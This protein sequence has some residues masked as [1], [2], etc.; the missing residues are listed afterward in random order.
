AGEEEG[1]QAL[2][3][4]SAH[5]RVRLRRSQPLVGRDATTGAGRRA[6][7][8]VH[9]FQA[10]DVGAAE[11]PDVFAYQ[12]P[13]ATERRRETAETITRRKVPLLVEHAVGWQIDLAVHVLELAPGKVQA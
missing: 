5:E 3:V 6:D 10:Q 2:G 11:V 7:D 4:G 9:A 8:H 13:R 1:R 12:H